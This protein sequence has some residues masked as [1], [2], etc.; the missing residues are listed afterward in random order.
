MSAVVDATRS[1]EAWL[2]RQ[3]AVVGPDLEH[4]HR[5][6]A[7][8]TFPFLRATYYRWAELFRATCGELLDAPVVLAVGDLHIENFGTWR[9]SEGRLV[10]GINDF[11]E[12]WPLP[13]TNDLVR[14][15]TSVRIASRASEW[16]AFG[17][18]CEAITAGYSEALRRG[19]L[20][21]VLEER[22][23]ALRTQAVERLASAAR[24]WAALERL[25][26]APAAAGRG[27]IGRLKAQLPHPG[28][29]VPLRRRRAGLGS[30]GHPR[31]V[32]LSEWRGGR[33]A[34]EAKAMVG[35]ANAW[36]ESPARARPRLRYAEI[37]RRAVRDPD[38]FLQ[39]E[40][41]WVIRRLSPD[42]SRIELASLPSKKDQQDWLQAM[43]WET[44]NIHL[45]TRGAAGRILA[46]LGARDPGWLKAAAKR[47][48]KVTRQDRRDW[49]AG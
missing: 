9:D 49:A 3:V 16:I 4:K 42:C 29:R 21:L 13:Y 12:A 35:S 30:L 8:A 5:E 14:L 31:L 28:R 46:D 26:V 7:A 1:Y 6:M 47:M 37:V 17:T 24:F 20:P 40:G 45:G 10:W 44:A 27:V 22:H 11:D 33:V 38:P 36:L 39:V 18:A 32:A 2:G 48:A 43:G 19:G 15:A 34:R 25:P 41:G 23:R